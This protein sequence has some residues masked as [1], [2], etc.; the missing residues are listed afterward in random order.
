MFWKSILVLHLY[1]FFLNQA[2]VLKSMYKQYLFCYRINQ[3]RSS[4]KHVNVRKH[5]W[6]D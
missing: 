2:L 4:H 1:I 3:S 6:T 5:I